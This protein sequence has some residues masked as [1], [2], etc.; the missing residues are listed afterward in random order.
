M[1][2]YKSGLA[3]DLGTGIGFL[4]HNGAEWSKLTDLTPSVCTDV[5]LE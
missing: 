1:Q 4:I 5:N 2:A 3:V